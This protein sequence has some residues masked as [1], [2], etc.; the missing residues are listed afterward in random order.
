MTK[1]PKKTPPAMLTGT[2][3]DQ[4]IVDMARLVIDESPEVRA[5]MIGVVYDLISR[6]KQRNMA[7]WAADPTVG[8]E[9]AALLSILMATRDNEEGL[10]RLA[11]LAARSIRHTG[12]PDAAA[13][14]IASY[15]ASPPGF[16]LFQVFR[17]NPLEAVPEEIRILFGGRMGESLGRLAAAGMY[18]RTERL[19]ALFGYAYSGLMASEMER[20]I[21]EEDGAEVIERS[22]DAQYDIRIKEIGQPN[23]DGSRKYEII[24]KEGAGSMADNGRG[25]YRPDVAFINDE[26]KQIVIGLAFSGA[27][28]DRQRD[29]IT[30]YLTPLLDST[31]IEDS[32]W[33]GYSITPFY[34]HAG[35][36]VPC[37]A[38]E[39]PGHKTSEYLIAKGVPD[40]Q[41][42]ALATLE[43]MAVPMHAV[44]PEQVAA[45]F[46]CNPLVAGTS[47][48]EH[49]RHVEQTA[50]LPVDVA[51]DRHIAFLSKQASLAAK[52]AA[53]IANA[54]ETQGIIDNALENLHAFLGA[55][56]NAFGG[57]SK[58]TFDTHWKPMVKT[59]KK[60]S[61]EVIKQHRHDGKMPIDG[62]RL[63][64][65]ME[66]RGATE[67]LLDTPHAKMQKNHH[68]K[69]GVRGSI[70]GV[71]ASITVI[72]LP[73]DPGP[74]AVKRIKR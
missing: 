59:I 30:K 16:D 24:A 20:G 50:H 54:P 22:Q 41:Q 66:L 44:A 40:E 55:P 36:F 39:R 37:D 7:E 52:A 63:H 46:R 38:D 10:E 1:P 9:R 70:A 15:I 53:A 11:L 4:A 48:L 56:E 23:P 35:T 64:L 31:K 6:G 71:A 17:K 8:P 2:A 29:E 57:M 42:R 68:E 21:V 45:F 27:N 74:S 62:L 18:V 25:P 65:W 33:F 32:P 5:Q 14:T 28:A 34:V 13:I 61:D 72:P 69:C 60:L 12:A 26:R 47:T 51:M 49:L 19:A 3:I 73:K 58:A 67:R 43:L